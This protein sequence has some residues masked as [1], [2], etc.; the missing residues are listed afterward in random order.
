MK[1]FLD[2]NVIFSA[3]KES[4]QINRLIALLKSQSHLLITSDYAREEAIRNIRKKRPDWES[5][6]AAVMRGIQ[7]IESMD[8]PLPVDLVAKDRPI[9]A[10]AIAHRC[11]Y[12]ITGDKR[13]FGH[14]LGTS[15]SGVTILTPLSIAEISGT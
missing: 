9:L 2:A 14:L 11:D 13:D 1:A 7:V 15:Q 3:S 8:R 12:L 5:G 6:F 10:T 4:S